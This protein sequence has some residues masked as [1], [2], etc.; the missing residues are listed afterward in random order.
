MDEGPLGGRTVRRPP[1]ALANLLVTLRTRARMS[2]RELSRTSEVSYT[3]IGDLERS[4]GGSPSPITLRALARGL[5]ADDSQPNGYNPVRADAFYRQ[6]MAAA[7]YLTGV[8][9]DA[10]PK[11]TDAQDVI[12]FLAGASG[13]TDI[14]TKLVRLAERWPELSVDDQM[15][16]RHLVGTWAKG[17]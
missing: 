2:Q 16:A 12:A 15:V 7:G 13:D 8:T 1:E 6:L 14:A 17:A 10:P 5:A 4:A 9:T 3:Q 11:Q